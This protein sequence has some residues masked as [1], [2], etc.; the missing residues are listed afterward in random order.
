MF[1]DLRCSNFHVAQEDRISILGAGRPPLEPAALEPLVRA[2]LVVH[3]ESFDKMYTTLLYNMYKR[4]DEDHVYAFLHLIRQGLSQGM[5]CT[6]SIAHKG[7]E[8]RRTEEFK[9]Y[10]V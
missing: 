4:G 2:R 1:L 8:P 10:I 6:A 3:D 7:L 5:P 9:N